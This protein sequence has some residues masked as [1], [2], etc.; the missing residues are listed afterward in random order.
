M[1]AD[2]ACEVLARAQAPEHPCTVNDGATMS[3]RDT[4][5]QLASGR[6]PHLEHSQ[7][8]QAQKDTLASPRR[9]YGVLARAL[10]GTL[11]TLYGKKRTLS[12]FK[13]L[14]LV[15]RVPYQSWE[16]VYD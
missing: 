12:K 11:D 5:G 1:T 3:I 10:F 7:L 6:P 9:H 2:A 15:A 14:E 13:V 4:S 16:H 8:V